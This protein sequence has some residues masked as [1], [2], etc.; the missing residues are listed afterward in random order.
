M[1]SGDAKTTWY[2][3]GGKSTGPMGGAPLVSFADPANA[4]S[5][6]RKNGGRMVRFDEVTPGMLR[7]DAKPQ[8]RPPAADGG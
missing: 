7:P 8:R 4:K 2:V 5:Y 1:Y 3:Y 6:I